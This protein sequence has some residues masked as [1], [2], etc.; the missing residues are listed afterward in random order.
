MKIKLTRKNHGTVLNI[1]RK[2]MN[3]PFSIQHGWDVKMKESKIESDGYD[4][5]LHRAALVTKHWNFNEKDAPLIHLDF[6]D[7]LNYIVLYEGDVI[8][9]LGGTKLIIQQTKAATI[10]I[11]GHKNLTF[12]I[13]QINDEKEDDLVKQEEERKSEKA[14]Y[15]SLDDDEYY[16]S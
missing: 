14:F 9:V 1:L 7:D 3:K 5:E 13:K 10:E 16:I 11:L 2:I 4:V 6:Q 8:K 15:D 12:I